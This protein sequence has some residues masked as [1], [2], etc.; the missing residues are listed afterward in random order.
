[1]KTTAALPKQLQFMLKQ[2]AI[3]I[4]L[5]DTCLHARAM[6]QMTEY[7]KIVSMRTSLQPDEGEQAYDG[8]AWLCS[9][10]ER[11]GQSL[12]GPQW[13]AGIPRVTNTEE[14]KNLC[15]ICG[16]HRI[17]EPLFQEQCQIQPTH[18]SLVV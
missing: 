16:V 18:R 3:P 6:S 5:H 1:M 9:L 8:I 13:S 2:V 4:P 14:D 15:A 11:R 7:L 12:R 17:Y 10:F